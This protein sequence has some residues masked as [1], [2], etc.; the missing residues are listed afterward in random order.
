VVDL[1]IIYCYFGLFSIG[2]FWYRLYQY[3][4]NLDPR[5]PMHIKPFTPLLLGSKQIA[6][7]RE[8]SYPELGAYLLCFSVLLIVLAGWFSRK[9]TTR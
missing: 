7:F 4:H 6:N 9:E 5:A 1:F 2:S 8:S 3:G